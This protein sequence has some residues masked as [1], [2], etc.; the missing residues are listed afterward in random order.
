MPLDQLGELG[1]VLW[2]WE[3]TLWVRRCTS[4]PPRPGAVI[5]APMDLEND[6]CEKSSVLRRG[7]PPPGEDISASD[8]HSLFLAR[9][10]VSNSRL[11]RP[12]HGIVRKNPSDNAAS[13]VLR[14][15]R[16]PVS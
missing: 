3:H 7:R 2:Q 5:S 4:R 6:K 12:E 13:G 1:L 9:R 10:K 8:G 16:R 15:S 14:E 11:S